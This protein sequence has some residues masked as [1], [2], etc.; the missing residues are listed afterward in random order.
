MKNKTSFFDVEPSSEHDENILQRADILLQKKRA[1][2]RRQFWTWIVLP[3][4][5]VASLFI[6]LRVGQNW[7]TESARQDLILVSELQDEADFDILAELDILEDMDE[8]E[9][10]DESSDT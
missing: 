4:S 1:E 2:K 5:A 7:G 10:W 9:A 8:L 3:A 6:A